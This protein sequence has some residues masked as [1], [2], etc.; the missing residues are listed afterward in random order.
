MTRT[1]ALWLAVFLVLATGAAAYLGAGTYQLAPVHPAFQTAALLRHWARQLFAVLP[2]AVAAATMLAFSGLRGSRS[3]ETGGTALTQGKVVLVILLAVGILHGVWYAVLDARAA[4]RIRHLEYLTTVAA[5][6]RNDAEQLLEREQPG[7]ARELLLFHQAL[8]GET[9]ETTMMLTAADR[10]AAS[11]PGDPVQPPV[12]LR[13]FPGTLEMTVVDLIRE[14]E[15]FLEAEDF[16]SAHHFA[17]LAVE[18][19][20]SRQDARRIRARAQA[21]IEGER[22]SMV[23]S[24]DRDFFAAKYRAYQAFHQGADIPERA[25]E[26]WYLFRELEQEAPGD[27]DVRT[28]APR[29]REQAM[30]ISFFVEDVR[31]YQHL[32]GHHNLFF[33]NQQT[34]SVVQLI[35]V[36]SLVR[37]REGDMLFGIEVLEVDRRRPEAPV[38]HQR[39][40]YG[41]VIRDRLVMRGVYREQDAPRGGPRMVLPEVYHGTEPVMQVSLMLEP[42]TLILAGGGE[43]A[44]ERLTLPELIAL[45]E[46]PGLSGVAV[47][48]AILHRLVTIAGFFA[49]MFAV[50]A[51]SHRY[52]STYLASLPRGVYLLLPLA[53]ATLWWVMATGRVVVDAGVVTLAS[54]TTPVVA[55]LTA[56]LVTLLII[57]V[58]VA[59]LGAREG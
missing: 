21:A 5:S 17:S 38:F 37:T 48:R 57:P 40:P 20:P 22:R 18:R 42:D 13:G 29:A 39:V 24:R 35:H 59:V 28:F 52:R 43:A 56:I 41:R 12:Q 1:F 54:A 14:A 7:E 25:V 26:A 47:S 9:V 44:L 6:L 3:D 32:A 45:A 49:L 31:Q 4:S 8:V 23:E 53:L 30:N 11:P 10:I 16:F 2:L 15:E 46:V 58:S 50:A 33:V 36:E 34:E 27:P 51:V 55:A 19:N